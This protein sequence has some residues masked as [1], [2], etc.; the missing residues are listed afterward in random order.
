MTQASI[1]FIEIRLRQ[2][3]VTGLVSLDI[4][5]E[6]LRNAPLDKFSERQ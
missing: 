5:T 2:L 3:G 4:D 1:K 6:D